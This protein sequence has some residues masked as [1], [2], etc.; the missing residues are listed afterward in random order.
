MKKNEEPQKS[1]RGSLNFPILC[2]SFHKDN[3][4]FLIIS[5]QLICHFLQITK[6]LRR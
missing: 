6:V 5:E 1:F 2:G 4:N 3:T